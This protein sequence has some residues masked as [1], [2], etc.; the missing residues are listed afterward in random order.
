MFFKNFFKCGFCGWCLECMWT[1]MGSLFSHKNR[2]LLCQT[3]LWMFP[4]YGLAAFFKPV[5]IKIGKCSTLLRGS[6]YTLCIFIAEYTTGSILKHY[7]A[8]PWDYS[9]SKYNYK[10][11]IRLDY[12]PAWF[13]AGLLF[14][15]IIKPRN[16]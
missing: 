3:S 16:N 6:I 12:A 9:R 7:N 10:G 4:I 5:C 15:N 13:A 1:G 11:L 2:Q 8:C 14:E